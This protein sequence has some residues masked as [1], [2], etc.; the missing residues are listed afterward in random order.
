VCIDTTPTL[1]QLCITTTPTL[2]QLCIAQNLRTVERMGVCVSKPTVESTR[3]SR[4]NTA[5][6]PGGAFSPTKPTGSTKP[7]N[8][9]ASETSDRLSVDA[10]QVNQV[11]TLSLVG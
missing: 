5:S 8:G 3:S 7:T 1:S 9:K 10:L 6:P 4:A 11:C 2:S